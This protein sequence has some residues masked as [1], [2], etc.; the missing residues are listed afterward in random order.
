MFVFGALIHTREILKMV[1]KTDLKNRI[2]VHTIYN[3]LYGF[4]VNR[5]EHIIANPYLMVL[6]VRYFKSNGISRILTTPNM[7]KEKKAYQEVLHK[8][9]TLSPV[10]NL[11]IR[12]MKHDIYPG[13]ALD[14]N[15]D[16][17]PAGHLNAAILTSNSSQRSVIGCHPHQLLY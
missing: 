6:I 5:L 2:Y 9:L 4:S 10:A 12:L 3:Y 15:D 13:L 11:A 8:L 7:C 17:I 1:G 14:I 16:I